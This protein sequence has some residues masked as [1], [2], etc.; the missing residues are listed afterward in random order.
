MPHLLRTTAI[1]AVLALQAHAVE[2][3]YIDG[4]H[5]YGH[6]VDF[7]YLDFE[8]IREQGDPQ[9]IF[10]YAKLHLR[11]MTQFEHGEPVFVLKTK[12]I[13][14]ED[15][16]LVQIQRVN[17]SD[18]FWTHADA[19]TRIDP[20]AEQ[21]LHS[22]QAREQAEHEKAK[23]SREAFKAE[24]KRM[25]LARAIAEDPHKRPPIAL[26]RYW[27]VG[28]ERFRGKLLNANKT[29][30]KILK[31][32][33]DTIIIDRRHLSETSNSYI[34]SMLYDLKVYR[35]YQVMIKKSVL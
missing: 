22:A 35:D 8:E 31:S 30:A 1:V 5:W 27:Q 17:Q 6:E 20:F 18:V 23:Q 34:D 21:K 29:H 26:D 24:A 3:A 13:E 4:H 2:R 14:P 10:A 7:C 9:G 33:E 15:I 12:L 11:N 16:P 25:Q 28:D 19:L 32:D